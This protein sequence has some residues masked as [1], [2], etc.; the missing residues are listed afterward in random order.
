MG[1]TVPSK[2]QPKLQ[3]TP[4]LT[5]QPPRI[6]NQRIKRLLSENNSTITNMMVSALFQPDMIGLKKLWHP[7]PKSNN[8]TPTFLFAF[9][10][11]TPTGPLNLF[12]NQP[13]TDSTPS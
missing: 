7:T 3:R 5:K 13:S 1:E 8:A 2:S 6:L 12:T 4:M 11:A 9:F 10:Q